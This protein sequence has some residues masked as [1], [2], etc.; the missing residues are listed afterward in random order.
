MITDALKNKKRTKSNAIILHL[1]G[2]K[3]YSKRAYNYYNNS[4]LKAI[5]ETI[6]EYKQPME[7][8]FLLEKYRPDILVSTGHDMMLK[9][10]QDLYKIENYKNSKCPNCEASKKVEIFSG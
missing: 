3:K 7:V 1:D 10:G 8:R 4:N 5:V 2:D 9:K 6:P